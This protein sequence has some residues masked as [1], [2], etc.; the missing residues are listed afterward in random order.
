MVD[1]GSIA[2]GLGFP[3]L[4][5]SRVASAGGDLDT[6]AGAARDCAERTSTY[7]Y[8]DDLDQLRRGGRIGAAASFFGSA[9]MIKPLLHI[10]GGTIQ[11]LEKVRTAARALARLEDLAVSAAG[12]LVVDLAVQHLASPERAASLAGRLAGRV[13]ARSVTVVEMG[14]VIGAHVGTGMLG[15]TVSPVR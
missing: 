10:E 7:F 2:F 9:L 8:V 5:A 11:P 13:S 6:V 3:V 12:G 14:A 1:S 15:V 4:E